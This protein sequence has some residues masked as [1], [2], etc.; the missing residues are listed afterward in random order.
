[1]SRII[2]AA[3]ALWAAIVHG[4]PFLPQNDG[5]VLQRLLGSN[6]E[7][8]LRQR[9]LTRDPSDLQQ[10]LKLAWA[11]LKLGREQ[12][13]PRY[14][15]YA[16]AMLEPWWAEARR[17]P[18]VLLLRATLRQSRHDFKGALEDLNQVLQQQ[19][20]NAQAWLT[21]SVVLAVLGEAQV[22]LS[23]CQPL[24]RL[25][26]PLLAASCR[27]NALSLTGE[28]ERAYALIEHAL[29][30]Q[31]KSPVDEQVWALTLL[32]E[33]ALRQSQP[34]LA[35]Q[36]FKAALDLPSQDIYLLAAYADFLLSQGRFQQVRELLKSKPRVDA[37]LLRLALAEQ[38]LDPARGALL[39]DA[40][41]ARL[42]ALQGRGESSH[43]GHLG[44]SARFWLELRQQADK[45]LR[46]A[47]AYWA[48]Q[49]DPEAARLLLAAAL[50]A[51]QAQAG[52]PVRN[53]LNRTGLRDVR[54]QTLLTRL[55]EGSG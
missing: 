17:W 53:W 24:R 12:A 13:D 40:F 38:Q 46:L 7:R 49:R 29:K 21:R 37:L 26:S 2:I 8:Q 3:L 31:P 6:S 32:A 34:A 35:E 55:G 54:L 33:I 43:L 51:K 18:G 11:W 20:R 48:Q 22:A 45:A 30:A 23:S 15:G 27:G 14:Y 41:E 19:P 28:A 39:A 9:T 10:A 42:R 36:H 1:M 50:A 44:D 47:Q 52:E 16:E 5:Q 25:A 4:K